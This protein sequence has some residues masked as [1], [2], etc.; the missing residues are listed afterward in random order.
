M[1]PNCGPMQFVTGM[2]Y[3]V[4]P[5]N[6]YQLSS[7]RQ[8]FLLRRKH[9]GLKRRKGGGGGGTQALHILA[10]RPITKCLQEDG[11]TC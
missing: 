7:S 8:L 1:I 2:L 11:Q 9:R 6:Q 3:S 4:T 10:A 5:Y